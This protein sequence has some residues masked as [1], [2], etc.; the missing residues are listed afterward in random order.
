[1]LI[2]WKSDAHWVALLR[3][4]SLILNCKSEIIEETNLESKWQWAD[5]SDYYAAYLVAVREWMIT[6]PKH[7]P[8]VIV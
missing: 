4:K 5:G 7:C 3:M 6:N 2:L 1:M 8:I